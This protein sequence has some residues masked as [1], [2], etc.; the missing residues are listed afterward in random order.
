MTSIASQLMDNKNCGADFRNQQP[1]VL[2]AYNGLVAYEPV[3]KAT[4]LKDADTTEYCFTEAV[5]NSSNSDD[6]YPYYTAIGLNLPAGGSPTCNSCLHQS[7]NIFA[8][9][10]VRKEQPLS[11][12]YLG[13]ADAVDGTCG[14]GFADTAVKVGSIKS[15]MGTQAA[16][17]KGAGVRTW[18]GSSVIAM[19]MIVS[20]LSL[21]ST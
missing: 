13:C 8:Q 1:L 5:T 16:E 18:A 10:A 11:S 4:C 6:V 14:A 12:T 19:A 21:T 15:G 20:L 17:M 9:Y 2:Q 3:Y 7:M